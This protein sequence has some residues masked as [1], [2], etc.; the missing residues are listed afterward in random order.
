MNTSRD[1]DVWAMVHAE[2]AALVADLA[3][4]SDE[5]WAAPSLCTGLSVREVVAHLTASASLGPFRWLAG[6]IRCRFDFDRQVAMR[7]GE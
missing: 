2:R 7:L 3:G 1:G 6:V 4:L 5:Q